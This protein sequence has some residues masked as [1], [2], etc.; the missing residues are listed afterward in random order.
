MWPS[1][2]VSHQYYSIFFRMCRSREKSSSPLDSRRQRG[3]KMGIM[4]K[5]PSP[6]KRKGPFLDLCHD[7][8]FKIYFKSNP[9]VLRSL[10]E[11]FLP[12]PKGRKIKSVKTIDP[13]MESQDEEGKQAVLDLRVQLDNKE[14]VNVEMQLFH[15]RGFK[16]RI[17]YYLT[18]LYSNPLPKGGKHKELYPAY[19]LVFAGFDM[20][21]DRKGWR[22]SFSMRSDKPPFFRFSGDLSVTIVELGKFLSLRPENLFD[23]ASLWCYLLKESKLMDMESARELAGK[24]KDMKE[25]TD[26]L[27]K[28]SKD[29]KIRLYEEARWMERADRLAREDYVRE[30]GLEQG[31][32]RGREEGRE[33]GREEGREQGREEGREQGRE[34]GLQQGIW[35][36]RQEE[37]RQLALKMLKKKTD[38]SFISEVTGFSETQIKKITNEN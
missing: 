34:E 12:L 17:L 6:H 14:W 11:S 30:E 24:G 36:G 26:H 35:K 32:Q 18:R 25:A 2:I 29:E 8:A 3:Y 19:S 4:T 13:F 1:E 16:K 22:H 27:I 23:M 9:L 15:Q 20:F 31:L 37:R 7:R 5:S 10:L 21:K 28:L 38:I 33:Q